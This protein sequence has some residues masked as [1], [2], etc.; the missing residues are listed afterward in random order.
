MNLSLRD[1]DIFKYFTASLSFAMKG[2]SGIIQ[3]LTIKIDYM[4]TTTNMKVLRY[5]IM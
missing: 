1:G 3:S 4:C 5:E 2:F